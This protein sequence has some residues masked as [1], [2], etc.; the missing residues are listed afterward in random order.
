MNVS[1]I[2]ATYN[3]NWNKL[4][5]TIKS[6]CIQKEINIQ[7]IFA[8][9]G[10][11][12][13]HNVKIVELLKEL[14]FGN[15]IFSDLKENS[16]TV[17]NIYNAC[18]Y[19]M[20]DY[21]K[22]ISPG[23][24]FYDNRVLKV[25]CES[26]KKYDSDVVFGN[27]VYYNCFNYKIEFLCK[28]LNPNFPYL[29]D[30]ESSYKKLFVDYILANDTILG[31]NLMFTTSFFIKYLNLIKDKVKFAEDMMLKIMVF[32]KAKITYI[33]KNLI[34]YDYGIGIS[35]N[36][37]TKKLIDDDKIK[38]EDVI[39]ENFST[40]NNSKI[41]TKYLKYLSKRKESKIFQ[42]IYKYVCFP[43]ILYWKAKSKFFSKRTDIN[44]NKNY[45]LNLYD[46]VN[47]ASN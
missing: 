45:I 9:D 34:Y 6:I 22:L 37:N 39:L 40:P 30:C 41:H 25:L 35:H 42:K 29:F 23:D 2:V 13:K 15:Y 31:A 7:I 17:L 43:S 18:Q 33:N 4:K 3:S 47:Y 16:G 5:A 20:Y 10:S 28:K 19:V 14:N 32:N 24:L 38:V 11:D 21:I 27:A 46:V 1:I 44:G 12:I 8:D 26:F 36:I